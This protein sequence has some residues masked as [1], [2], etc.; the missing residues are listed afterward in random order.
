MSR[1]IYLKV[2]N[3]PKGVSDNDI[4]KVMNEIGLSP[5]YIQRSLKSNSC[6]VRVL[7]LIRT[8]RKR[9]KKNV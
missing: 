5:L 9:G 8:D 2:Y 6:V 4:I 3:T 7:P 1:L